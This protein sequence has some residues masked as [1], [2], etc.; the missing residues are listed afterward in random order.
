MTKRTIYDILKREHEEVSELFH[1]LEEA[2]GAEALALYSQLKLKLVPHAKAEE[3]VVYP[4]FLQESQA[5]DITR[6]GI[7]EH[8]QVDHLLAE[9][10]GTSTDAENWT[11]KLKVLADMVGHHVDEEELQM[12]PLAQQSLSERD[13]AQLADAYERERDAWIEHMKAAEQRRTAAA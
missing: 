11:A 1:E 4:R 10:D 3:A 2:E 5:V 7:E 12:F 8:K 13:A 9:L 6:E